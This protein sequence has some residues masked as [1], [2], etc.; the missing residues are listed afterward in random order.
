MKPVLLFFFALGS[1]GVC[2]CYYYYYYCNI[3]EHVQTMSSSDT[4]SALIHRV[5]LCCYAA[6]GL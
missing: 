4:L 2:L 5:C 6:V 3:I 1:K